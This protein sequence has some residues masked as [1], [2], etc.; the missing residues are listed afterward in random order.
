LRT[1]AAL[2]ATLIAAAALTPSDSSDA[3]SKVHLLVLKE[4]GLGSAS[5]AQPYVDK[6]VKIA[7][8]KN[9]WSAAEGKYLTSRSRAESYIEKNDPHYGL[10]SLGAFLAMHKSRKLEVL[11]SVEVTRGGG[12][13]YHLVSKSASSLKDCK[14]KKLASDHAEDARFVDKVVSGGDFTLSDFKLEKTRRPVQTIKAAIRGEATCA[15]IDDAQHAELSHIDGG[16]GLK[17]VWKSKMLPAMPVVAFSS[18]PG[19]ERAK[20]KASLGALCTGAGKESCD[21]VGIKSLSPSSQA[22]YQSVLSAYAK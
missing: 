13:Q 8:E 20:F 22:A 11:G 3:A 5:Q 15:L 21:K 1:A 14:G 16:K 10:I 2:V 19:A 4:H 17:S 6:L 12:R 7:A 18:A 9:G